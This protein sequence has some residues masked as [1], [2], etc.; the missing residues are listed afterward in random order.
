MSRARPQ[1]TR[2]YKNHHLDSTRWEQVPLRED[3]VIISTSLKTG[4]TWTQRILSLLVFGPGPLPMSLQFWPGA[5]AMILIATMTATLMTNGGR[6]AWFVGAMILM[7]YAIF[8]LALF[9]L[10]PAA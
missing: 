6:T 9:L 4:T 8:G 5:V 3:D 7:I 2:V 10:P 1:Q